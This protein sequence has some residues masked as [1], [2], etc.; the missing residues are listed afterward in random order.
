MVLA[1]SLLLLG[2]QSLEWP[3]FGH[4]A[5]RSGTEYRDRSVTPANVARLHLRWRTALGGVADSTPIIVSGIVMKRQVRTMLFQTAKS[6]TTYGIDAR[7]GKIQWRFVTHGPKITTSTPVADASAKWIYAP[8][9]DGFVHKLQAAT[10]KEV[11]SSGFPVRI[12]RM[13]ETE[14]HASPLN[15]ANGYLY[16]VTSGY[17]GDAPPYVG[18][19][20]GVRLSDGT[21]HVFNALCGDARSLPTAQTCPE[22]GSGIWSRGGAVVDPEPSM[23]GRVYVATGNGNFNANV[24]GH[25]YGDSVLALSADATTVAGYYTSPTNKRLQMGDVDLGSSSPSLLPRQTDSKTPLMLVQGG[26]D[27]I[28]RLLNRSPLPHVGG[29]LQRLDIGASLYST[30]AVWQ[31]SAHR[32]WVF[33]GLSDQV[34]AYRIQ[35]NSEGISRLIHEWSSNVGQTE[36]GTSPVISG[37]VVFIAMNGAI[38]AL[39]APSGR[40]LWNS[41]HGGAAQ[42][43]GPVHWQ[44]PIVVNGVVYCSDE[45]GDLTAYGL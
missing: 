10:G 29:E 6:G 3:T 7:D 34:R 42:S 14:K 30:P 18:H 26:K 21:E 31:D 5:A 11:Y 4:D 41:R 45:N 24:G 33:L 1:G 15:L 2:A 17:F 35:T 27:R 28:L 13:P 43:I 36:E 38:Y 40:E 44:S 22:S 8:G 32:T 19:V 20:V 9:V 16:A 23:R 25:D 37:G 12:T 39:D